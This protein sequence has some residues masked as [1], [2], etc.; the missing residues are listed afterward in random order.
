MKKFKL[1]SLL[2]IISLFVCMFPAH[3]LALDM[4]V[5]SAGSAIVMDV[6]T[7]EVLYRQNETQPFSPGTLTVLMTALVVSDAI[8][9]QSIALDDP[10]TAS[11]SFSY[12]LTPDTGTAGILPG[13]IMTVNDLLYCAALTSARDACNILA[14][15]T[16][17]S[18]D[19]FVA[20]MNAKA[21][22]L[23]CASTHFVNANGIEAAGQ[24]TSVQDLA[25]IIRALTNS[26]AA[27][28]PF[29]V[30]TH[31]VAATNM[32][33][34]RGLTNANAMLDSGSEYYYEYLYGYKGAQL[35]NGTYAM[36]SAASYNEMDIIAIVAGSPDS[37]SRYA[38]ARTLLEW[39][40]GNFSYREILSNTQSL[41]TLPVELGDPGTV[42]IRAE[43]QLRIILPNDQ[44][45]GNVEYRI[46]YRH[47][48]EGAVLQAPIS[49]AQYMG[50]VTVYLDGVEQGSSKLVAASGVDISRLEYLRT[51]LKVLIQNDSVRQLITILA[52]ILG[53]YILLVAFYLIQRLLHL[54]SL[55][56]ARKDRAI[57]RARQEIE[58]LDIP[59][60]GEGYLRQPAAREYI[61]APE[62]PYAPAEADGPYGDP[63]EEMVREYN[64][65][66]S[67]PA[68]ASEEYDD[69]PDGEEY[70][71]DGEYAEDEEYTDDGEYAEDGEYADDAEYA[72]D[73]EYANDD[74]YEDDD[75]DEP[76]APP[77]RRRR[78]GR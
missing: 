14:E 67:G 59:A 3:A 42:N 2:L 64:G 34:A 8:D 63:R 33:A 15:H 75:G 20:A 9:A 73:G 13:E 36:A 69:A 68:P 76:P 78:R 43:D 41:A 11:G 62:A 52:V 21:E 44:D 10:V 31:T 37:A 27:S 24:Q 61:P 50:D 48:Q 53:I 46:T 40:F 35:S 25:L 72:D 51:Q 66:Q 71:E 45:L 47:E 28:T 23:G 18:V 55:R 58:W 39:V 19:A 49:A 4:P 74:D 7:G 56:R 26:S 22:A 29:G 32:T 54:H 5:L 1:L 17:G 38:D 65:P 30:S 16:S 60:Q 57:A 70:A 77:T 6:K 12:N